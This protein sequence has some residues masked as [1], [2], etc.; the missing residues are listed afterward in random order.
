MVTN[1]QIKKIHTLKNLLKL[2]DDLY[3]D[4]LS[5]YGADSCK[6]LAPHL[7][8]DFIKHLESMAIDAGLW[9]KPCMN[10]K[11]FDNRANM[12]TAKQLRML[13][14]MWSSL[15]TTSLE[16]KE[17]K[18]VNKR[19]LIKKTLRKFLKNKF[20]VSDLRFLSKDKVSKVR[21]AISVM[22]NRQLNTI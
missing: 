20:G 21:K 1:A 17:K 14:A 13:E 8:E 12:A 9:N 18:N 10:Y 15:I 6:N 3:R 7:I 19:R 4:V 11:S 22:I 5:S 2:D 16:K